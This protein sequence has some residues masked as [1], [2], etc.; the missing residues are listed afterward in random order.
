MLD[1]EKSEFNQS[2]FSIAISKFTTSSISDPSF[3][4]HHV[5]GRHF[6]M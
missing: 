3:K 2:S 5:Q 4:H 1:N 6:V